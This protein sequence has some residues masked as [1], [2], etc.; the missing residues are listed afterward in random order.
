MESIKIDNQQQLDESHYNDELIDARIIHEFYLWTFT[1]VDG[2]TKTV[3]FDNNFFSPCDLVRAY[4][5]LWGEDW[6][7]DE[8]K[9]SYVQRFK[10]WLIATGCTA[11]ELEDDD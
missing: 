8:D 5:S 6:N 7:M 4:K 9:P 3:P 1:N 10:E 11:E 2:E